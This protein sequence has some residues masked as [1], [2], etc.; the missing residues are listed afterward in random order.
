LPHG[1]V[2]YRTEALSVIGVPADLV[3]D[4]GRIGAPLR[5]RMAKRKRTRKQISEE[6]RVRVEGSPT[7]R[8][9]RELVAKGEA[10][11]RARGE[12]TG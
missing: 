10:E 2:A 3:V 8:R 1:A 5:T 11:L 12:A 9:L 6:A 7:V 4:V